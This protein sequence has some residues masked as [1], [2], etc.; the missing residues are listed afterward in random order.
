MTTQT[1][2][3]SQGKI[4]RSDH[5][6]FLYYDLETVPDFDLPAILQDDILDSVKVRPM[7][8]P[9]KAA[10]ALEEK[11][12]KVLDEFS[13]TPLTNRII[14][15]A[16]AF[17]D[18]KPRAVYGKDEKKLIEKFIELMNKGF[19]KIQKDF[20]SAGR[21]IPVTYN[22]LS[23]DQFILF[24]K[25]VQHGLDLPPFNL[26]VPRYDKG[27]QHIDLRRV[28][29]NDDKFA[30]GTLTQWSIR[31]GYEGDLLEHSGG[32]IRDL[33]AE[34]KWEEIREKCKTDVELVRFIHSKIGRYL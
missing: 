23:F 24:M 4:T 34:E 15:I 8:D 30:R 13:L 6:H 18:E 33:F 11:R 32:Q 25:V 2:T 16:F 20:G 31:L 9:E 19:D 10:E 12:A 3:R 1:R 5:S 17:D 26:R 14:C 22:G 27:D 29:S 7:K 28:F 21:I